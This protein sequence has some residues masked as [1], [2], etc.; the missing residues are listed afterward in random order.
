[1][2]ILICVLGQSKVYEEAS[3]LIRDIL[4]VDISAP[5]IQRV[6]NYYGEQ[7]N[8]LVK[9]NFETVI[10]KLETKDKRDPT[11]VMM[12]GSMIYTRADGW[13]EMKLGRIF[14]G[15]QIVDIQ[16]SRREIQESIYVSHLGSVEEFLPKFERHLVP[17]KNKVI[18]GDGAAWIWKWAEDNYPGATQV[19]DFFHAKEKL[20]ILAKH[21]FT[22]DKKRTQWVTHQ[23]EKLLDNG[24]E[25]VISTLKTIRA[26][27]DEAKHAKQK[28]IDYYEEHDDRMLYRTYKERGLLIGS[29]PIEAAH[30]SVIQQRMKLSGQKWTV[31]GANAI[32]NLR[33]YRQSGAW[34]IIENIVAAA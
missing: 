9:G 1:M 23:A 12:D 17:Y 16:Q 30:R 28:A 7:I 2:R 5:Q 19:L 32:A 8:P 3:E 4:N 26:R 31:K 18:I 13:R 29:G 24:V 21:Q 25:Q 11:Y 20:V 15:S 6:C 22:D 33:C 14:H 27:N 34:H 10:P